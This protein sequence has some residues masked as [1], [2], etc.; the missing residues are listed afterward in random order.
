[1]TRISHRNEISAGRFPPGA[2]VLVDAP[3]MRDGAYV[4]RVGLAEA[5][6]WRGLRRDV[7]WLRGTTGTLDQQELRDLGRHVFE[8]GVDERGRAIDWTDCSEALAQMWLALPGDAVGRKPVAQVP[9]RPSGSSRYLASVEQRGVGGL[10]VDLGASACQKGEPV[11]GLLFW[12][13]AG[14]PFFTMDR[15]QPVRFTYPECASLVRWP[16][17]ARAARTEMRIDI[18]PSSLRRGEARVALL[19][20]PAN[21][22]C[23]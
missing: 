12:R 23:H 4:F 13:A 8:I 14:A 7:A 22:A 1:M 5:A 18:A 16:M 9:L 2:V 11:E 20:R 3:D 10:V 19:P 17:D 6:R 21:G 15:S